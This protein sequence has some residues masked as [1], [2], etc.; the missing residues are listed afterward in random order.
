MSKKQEAVTL[1]RD[2]WKW[3]LRVLEEDLQESEEIGAHLSAAKT[4]RII[5]EIKSRKEV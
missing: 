5:K 1:S 4:E 2:E 3:V